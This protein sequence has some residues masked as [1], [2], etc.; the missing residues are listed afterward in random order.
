MPAYIAVVSQDPGS[1]FGVHFPDVPGCFSAADE[2]AELP[3]LAQ[4]ALALHLEGEPMPPARS[5]AAIRNDPEVQASLAE[6]AFLLA[7]PLVRLTGRTVRA[8]ITL[9]AGLL[10]AIDDTAKARGITRSAFLA[11]LARREIAAK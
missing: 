6:G 5:L 4:E 1:A 7:V 9:D 2:L 10:H 8:N 11:D 3:S